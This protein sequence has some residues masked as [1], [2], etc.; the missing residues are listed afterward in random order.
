VTSI[1]I[2]VALQ[3]SAILLKQAVSLEGRTAHL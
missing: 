3:C 1:V 2:V